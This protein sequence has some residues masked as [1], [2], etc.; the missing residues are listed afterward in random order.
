VTAN[1]KTSQFGGSQTLIATTEK[2]SD[3]KN[4]GTLTT[5]TP[6][7]VSIGPAKKARMPAS[8]T[9]RKVPRT[10]ADETDA[11]IGFPVSLVLLSRTTPTSFF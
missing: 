6:I 10:S 4:A 1:H 7:R 8:P 3:L 9:P 11:S 5:L 2:E